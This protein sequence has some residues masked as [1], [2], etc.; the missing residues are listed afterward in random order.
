MRTVEGKDKRIFTNVVL[1]RVSQKTW[2]VLNRI[3]HQLLTSCYCCW[4]ACKFKLLTIVTYMF[5][6]S[7]PQT[8]RPCYQPHL[9][10]LTF[11]QST[12]LQSILIFSCKVGFQRVNISLAWPS[13]RPLTSGVPESKMSLA[14][15]TSRSRLLSCSAARLLS[16]R[17]ACSEGHR[18][19]WRFYSSKMSR[20]EE[21]RSRALLGGGQRR[22][23]KQHKSVWQLCIASIVCLWG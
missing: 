18:Q 16:L 4:N 21:K 11:V 6:Q 9:A 10:G 8:L 23:D 22:L 7:L 14:L 15:C 5:A 3:Y 13:S 1:K 2:G 20:L 12:R 17:V 19:S